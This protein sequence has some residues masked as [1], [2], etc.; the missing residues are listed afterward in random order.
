VGDFGLKVFRA[1]DSF[2]SVVSEQHFQSLREGFAGL[3]PEITKNRSRVDS[4][5]CHPVPE[6]AIE[7]D[8][9]EQNQV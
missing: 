5:D 8:E 1:D 6:Q 7:G 2:R 4:E 9:E 3:Q